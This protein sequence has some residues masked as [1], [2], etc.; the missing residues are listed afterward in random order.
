[1]PGRAASNVAIN[2]ARILITAFVLIF[3]S[4]RIASISFCLDSE[5]LTVIFFE[6]IIKPK[7]SITCEGKYFDFS[8]YIKIPRL[9]ISFTLASTAF[10]HPLNVSPI[11]KVSSR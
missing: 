11:K 3:T 8:G 7:N 1:M 6:F 5:Q 4:L 9:L 2:F 10:L